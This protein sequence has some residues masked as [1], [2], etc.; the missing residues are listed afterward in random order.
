MREIEIRIQNRSRAGDGCQRAEI[1]AESLLNIEYAPRDRGSTG[2]KLCIA[3]DPLT[4]TR[5][6]D[7]SEIAG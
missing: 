6:D 5:F 2:V 7:I 4:R 1:E 3:Y